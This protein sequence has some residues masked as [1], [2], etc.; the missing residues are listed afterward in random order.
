MSQK[1]RVEI[2]DG[3]AWITMDD[4]KV[5]ALSSEMIAEI[6]EA[7]DSAERAGAVVV[8]S[9][10]EGIFSAG[11]DLPTFKRGLD[12][13]VAMVRA[14]A[15]L[16]E[17]LLALPLPVL[18]VCTGHAYPMGACSSCC[19]PTSALVSRAPGGSG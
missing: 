18:T 6:G 12:E 2:A 5:N 10:R 11:F 1:T 3:I 17:R 16:I 9:G 4:G 14:G 7:L 15:K 19:P 13:S 8:L